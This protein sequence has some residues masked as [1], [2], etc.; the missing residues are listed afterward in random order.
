MKTERVKIGGRG[1]RKGRGKLGVYLSWVKKGN[2]GSKEEQGE[3][4][5][6]RIWRKG[7]QGGEGRSI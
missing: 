3:E 4:E 1:S 5:K 6:R 7:N 2:L